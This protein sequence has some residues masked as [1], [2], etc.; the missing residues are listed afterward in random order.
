MSLNSSASWIR[1]PEKP[2]VFPFP[3]LCFGHFYGLRAVWCPKHFYTE[4]DNRKLR[5]DVTLIFASYLTV[6]CPPHCYRALTHTLHIFAD[7][8]ML[9]ANLPQCT[10]PATLKNHVSASLLTESSVTYHELANWQ[11]VC[12]SGVLSEHTNLIWTPTEAGQICL[13]RLVCAKQRNLKWNVCVLLFFYF[14]LLTDNVNKSIWDWEGLE[15]RA[16]FDYIEAAHTHFACLS[17]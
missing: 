1:S 2:L 5:A 7:L 4:G 3:R 14:F 12:L 6:N 17:C 8:L 13:L 10:K 15:T 9:R 16:L 11:R